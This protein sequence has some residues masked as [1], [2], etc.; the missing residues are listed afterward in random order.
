MSTTT[1]IERHGGS[2]AV[3]VKDRTLY[4]HAEPYASLIEQLDEQTTEGIYSGTQE[5][6]WL[7]AGALAREYGYGDAYSKGR[8]GGWLVVE[9]A[10]SWDEYISDDETRHDGIAYDDYPE[11]AFSERATWLK[12]ADEIRQ[13]MNFQRSEILRR[14]REAVADLEAR[15]DSNAVRGEN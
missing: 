12:F 2:P 13:E 3:N 7:A 9:K 1:T 4:A 14:L 11:N 15:R 10:P 8:S 5:D 6:F